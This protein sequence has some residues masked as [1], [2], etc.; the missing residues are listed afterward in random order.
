MDIFNFLQTS[1]SVLVFRHIAQRQQADAKPLGRDILVGR[2]IGLSGQ[3]HERI[4]MEG[5]LCTG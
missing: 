2:Q 5:Q 4:K 1:A 3:F